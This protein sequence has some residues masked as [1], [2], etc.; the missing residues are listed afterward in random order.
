MMGEQSTIPNDTADNDPGDE[1]VALE[2]KSPR[3]ACASNC[4]YLVQGHADVKKHLELK[5]C[6]IYPGQSVFLF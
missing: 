3:R 5:R 6:E 1:N 4:A 2:A